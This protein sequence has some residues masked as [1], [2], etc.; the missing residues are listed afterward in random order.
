MAHPLSIAS[1][2]LETYIYGKWMVFDF[3][4][5]NKDKGSPLNPENRIVC[6][7]WKLRGQTVRD[8]YGNLLECKEFWEAY[9]E[10]DYLVAFNGKFEAGWLLRYGADPTDKLWADPMIG[11]KVR[12]GNRFALLNLGDVSQRY[13]FKGKE[14]MID[15]MMKGGV[16]PSDM[17][18]RQLRARNRRDTKTTEQ[19]WEKQLVGLQKEGKLKVLLTRCLL[20]PILAVIERNGMH[21]DKERV[22]KTHEEYV[23]KLREVEREAAEFTGG[24]NMRSWKQKATYLYGVIEVPTVEGDEGHVEGKTYKW[25]PA[26]KDSKEWKT[27]LRFK[28]PTDKRGRPRRNK[29]KR[30]PTGAP[31][32]DNDTMAWLETQGATAKQRQFIDIRQR[33]GKL[34]AAVSKNLNFFR[35]IVEEREKPVFYG[36]FNQVNT[37][38]HRLSSSGIPQVFKMFPGK[39]PSVQFQN[40]PRAFK[41]LFTVRDPD[42]VYVEADGA[43]LEFVVAAFLGQDRVAIADIRNPRFDAHI[44]TATV[45]RDPNFDGEINRELYNEL[46]EKKKA[47]DKEVKEW[48]QDAKPRTFKPLYGGTQGTELEMRYYQWFQQNYAELYGTQESWV[49]EVLSTGKLK[50]PWGMRFYWDFYLNANGT[51]MDRREHKSIVPAIFNYPVQSLATAE[52]IPI[53]LVHLYHRVKKA[54]LRVL[55]VNTVHDSVNAEVHKDDVEKYIELVHKSF[56][57][58]VYRYL[59]QVYGLK[60]NVPLGCEVVYGTHWGEG[61]EVKFKEEPPV[62]KEAA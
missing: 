42:Y 17:P 9:E 61:E 43:Q 34:D 13:G 48:R 33:F 40:M 26:P 8:Y 53:A 3:E 20:T 22:V 38:T 5:T 7:S 18:E 57:F 62:Y 60:F 58:D 29:S 37:D 52:I 28:E 24:I 12:L 49:S 25:V 27:S 19:I 45:M 39:E 11:E 30:N 36:Q 16:C 15:A 14:T 32:T 21:L 31:K 10:A 6:A 4:T 59:H 50:L 1:L 55:F 2:N 51:P 23:A 44:Q 54:G 41:P 35:G 46:L 47:G 56:T